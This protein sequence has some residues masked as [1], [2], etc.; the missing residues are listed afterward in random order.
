M[1]ETRTKHYSEL[2][3]CDFGW[4]INKLDTIPSNVNSWGVGDLSF[5]SS[6]KSWAEASSLGFNRND[7]QLKIRDNYNPNMVWSNIV[8]DTFDTFE[9]RDSNFVKILNGS[10][11][12]EYEKLDTI[13]FEYDLVGNTK[14]ILSNKGSESISN[15][16]NQYKTD[17]E[18]F[19]ELYNSFDAPDIVDFDAKNFIQ[20]CEEIYKMST[21]EFMENF[22]ENDFEGNVDMQLWY[23]HAKLLKIDGENE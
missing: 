11:I 7:S 14:N 13:C 6:R 8:I 16:E 17:E 9:L 18:L 23:H 12:E 15:N 2:E 4:N 5:F 3:Y 21:K 1:Y 22:G 19:M 20:E 10:F